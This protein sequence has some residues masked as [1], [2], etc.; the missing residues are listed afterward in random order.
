MLAMFIADQHFPELDTAKVVRLA[1]LHDLGEID[2]GDITPMD[3]IPRTEKVQRERAAVVRVL[4]RLPGGDRYVALWDEYEEGRSAE[5]R[6]VR[7]VEKLEMALQASVYE[8]QKL[9]SLG[10][11]FAS[12]RP[13]LE[14][15][16]LRQLL[17]AIEELRDEPTV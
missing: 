8:H 12:A 10:D 5:S 9:A 6:F 1:L 16:P 15:Q 11:F 7:Q 17:A 14:D 13:A 3:Q 2:A 4:R